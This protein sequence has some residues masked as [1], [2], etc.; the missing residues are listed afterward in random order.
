MPSMWTALHRRSKMI[1]VDSPILLFSSHSWLS[2][3]LP[4][5][6]FFKKIACPQGGQA[7]GSGVRTNPLDVFSIARQG[8]VKTTKMSAYDMFGRAC[9]QAREAKGWSYIQAMMKINGL[10]DKRGKPICT[11]RS[12][13]RWETGEF[14][15]KIEPTKAMAIVYGRPDLISLRIEA[16][17]FLRKRKGRLLEQTVV[18]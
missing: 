3:S 5:R 2:F 14:L 15:P 12:L 9:R 7:L 13:V 18:G 6:D 1:P 8:E 4:Y 17:E 16:I 10:C 11:E